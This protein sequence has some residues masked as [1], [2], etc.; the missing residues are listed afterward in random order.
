MTEKRRFQRIPFRKELTFKCVKGTHSGE[1]KN[2]SLGGAY[3]ENLTNYP[4]LRETV[5]IAFYLENANNV[6]ISI[7]GE[8][9]RVE[10]GRGF[11]V[12]FVEID[13]TSFTHLKNIIY[14]NSSDP[15]VAK[16]EIYEFLG[17]AYPMFQTVKYLAVQ[18]LKNE[19]IKYLLSRAFL[20]SPDKPFILSS[21][22]ESPY[23]LDCRKV[24]LYSPSFQLIGDL[25]WEEVRFSFVDGVAGMSIEGL[26]VRKEPKKHGTHKQIEG[27]IKPGMRIVLVEDVVT[28]GGSVLKALSA[29]REAGAQVVKVLALVDREEGGRSAIEGEEVP[30][31]AFFTIEEIL[32]A[33]KAQKSILLT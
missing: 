33:Y 1:L 10:E 24:T 20:Y 13:P 3:I 12:K 4:Y 17:E 15:E 18:S 26:L 23:Y 5:E 8:V 14:Y 27:N 11:A 16:K 19:L 7:K 21:G 6:V 32:S 22:K 2:L 9:V 25:F 30:F 31:Q 29:L 28:T